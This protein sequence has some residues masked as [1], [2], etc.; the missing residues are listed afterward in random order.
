MNGPHGLF[1]DEWIAPSAVVN[2]VAVVRAETKS[3][4]AQVDAEGDGE[5][6]SWH[7][8]EHAEAEDALSEA[9]LSFCRKTG[10]KLCRVA[11]RRISERAW[12]KAATRWSA[13]DRRL[14]SASAQE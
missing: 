6:L 9:M 4:Y 13:S 11:C 12:Q 8:G 1:V 7:T 5:G 3:F 14:S 2:V 10:Q